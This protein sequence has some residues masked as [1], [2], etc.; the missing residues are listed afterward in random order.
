MLQLSIQKKISLGESVS[1]EFKK[2]SNGI[3]SDVYETVCS[4][5]TSFILLYLIISLIAVA[6]AIFPV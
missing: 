5:L 2:C 6:L 4:F 1:L 3:H